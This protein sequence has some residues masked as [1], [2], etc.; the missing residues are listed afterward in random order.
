MSDE[1]CVRD[2]TFIYRATTNF[3]LAASKY[4]LGACKMKVK[5]SFIHFTWKKNTGTRISLDLPTAALTCSGGVYFRN[6]ASKRHVTKMKQKNVWTTL[7]KHRNDRLNIIAFQSQKNPLHN[8]LRSR[9]RLE[10]LPSNSF[11]LL[12]F[13]APWAP[14]NANSVC[15]IA[16]AANNRGYSQCRHNPANANHNIK[17]LDNNGQIYIIHNTH[18]EC[19]TSGHFLNNVQSIIYL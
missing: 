13:T 11:I 1:G 17:S 19:G 2:C 15:S 5:F 6:T 4:H 7:D 12:F 8:A 3:K 18:S 14:A 9:A 10:S 16:L